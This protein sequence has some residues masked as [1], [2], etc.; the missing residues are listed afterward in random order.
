AGISAGVMK[1]F[2]VL[3]EHGANPAPIA[4][5]LSA[6]PG[7]DGAVAPNQWHKGGD[8][9]VEAFPSSDGASK[10]VR[11]TISLVKAELAGTDATLGGVAA[12]D[13]DFVHAV[14]SNFPYV[15]GFVLL[16]TFILLAR[17][18]RSLVLPLKAAILNLVSLGAAYGIIVFIFQKGHGS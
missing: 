8:S 12:E 4:A 2:D 16:L 6:T 13:R 3:V 17:A 9:I 1:P 7:I 18:F 15:L 10:P 5:K 14:Y 11:H